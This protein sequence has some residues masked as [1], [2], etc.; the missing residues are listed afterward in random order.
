MAPPLFQ[1]RDHADYELDQCDVACASELQSAFAEFMQRPIDLSLRTFGVCCFRVAGVIN[2]LGLNVHHT[3][4][5][6]PSMTLVVQQMQSFLDTLRQDRPI[7]PLEPYDEA[8]AGHAVASHIHEMLNASVDLPRH[9]RHITLPFERV[10]RVK[11]VPHMKILE[12]DIT[13]ELAALQ[14]ASTILKLSVNALLVGTLAWL[15]H[16]YSCKRDLAIGQTYFGRTREQ[17]SM[18]GRYREAA[19]ICNMPP[20]P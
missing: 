4:M 12:R 8:L 17:M 5:D 18:V 19:R 11:D 2:S 9:I 3:V 6:G 15:L 20:H 14:N 16:L 13:A 7:I 10:A 1:I